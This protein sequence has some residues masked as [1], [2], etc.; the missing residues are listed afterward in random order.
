MAYEAFAQ[1]YD[2]LNEGADYDGLCAVIC[3]YFTE[4]GLTQGIVADLGCGT[5]EMSLRL[6]QKG[7]DLIA[8]DASADMLNELLDKKQQAGLG[9]E[10][11]ALCQPLEQLDLY[12]T[13]QGAVSLFDTVNHIEPENLARAF[14]RVG[15][16]MESGGVFVFD[17]NTPYKH[18]IILADNS[19]VASHASRPDISCEWHNQY[20]PQQQCTRICVEVYQKDELL[21]QEEFTEYIFQPEQI[22]QFLHSAGFVLR[23]VLDGERFAPPQY[24]SQRLM[25]VAQKI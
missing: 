22:E 16:F 4:Y 2:S 8:V 24:D 13:I 7:Y 9:N 15:L 14:Q 17:Y 5:G 12:G 6:A 25:V 3:K 21:L 11:L 10:I 1:F 20:C 18:E 19:F 23:H